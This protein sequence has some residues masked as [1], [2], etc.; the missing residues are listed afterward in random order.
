MRHGVLWSLFYTVVFVG[1]G[2]RTFQRK[3]VLS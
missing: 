3:D 2:Y 1:L